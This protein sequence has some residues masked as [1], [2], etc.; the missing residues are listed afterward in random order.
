MSICLPAVLTVGCRDILIHGD[1]P[2]QGNCSTLNANK[3]FIEVH[4]VRR[5]VNLG[6]E[7]LRITQSRL[8]NNTWR[9]PAPPLS[10]RGLPHLQIN[11]FKLFCFE[12]GSYFPR[13]AQNYTAQAGFELVSGFSASAFLSVGIPSMGHHA[14]PKNFSIVTDRTQS[15]ML[16]KQVFYHWATL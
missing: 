9:L 16:T 3:S 15:C 1:H 14:Q 4:W 2:T 11:A 6:A 7:L 12:I 10:G 5:Y 13:L 8:R